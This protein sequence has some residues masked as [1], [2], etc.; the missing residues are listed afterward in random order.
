MFSHLRSILCVISGFRR[1]VC[2]IYALLGITT[3]R[4]VISQKS[5]DLLDELFIYVM[6]KT[7][8]GK[9]NPTR[10]V[11]R[12]RSEQ[13]NSN[14]RTKTSRRK[15]VRVKGQNK[16]KTNTVRASSINIEDKTYIVNNNYNYI[17]YDYDYNYKLM[18]I[19]GH[20]F[21]QIWLYCDLVFRNPLHRFPSLGC[22]LFVTSTVYK[23]PAHQIMWLQHGAFCVTV[24]K[25]THPE[26]CNIVE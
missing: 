5:A 25:P 17:N 4:C 15:Q 22:W 24:H 19:Y 3:V 14:N 12:E 16:T 6:T 7:P 21:Q 10:V 20:L 18:Y 26:S 8:T 23:G 1:E 11:R 13:T 9:Y 2:E